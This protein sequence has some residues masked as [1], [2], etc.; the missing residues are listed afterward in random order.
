MIIR[1]PKTE[2]HAVAMAAGLHGYSVEFYTD[3]RAGGLC[4]AEINVPEDN[5]AI[6]VYLGREI[7]IQVQREAEYIRTEDNLFDLFRIGK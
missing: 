2:R 4:F 7:E 3:E 5:A 6:L 1:I